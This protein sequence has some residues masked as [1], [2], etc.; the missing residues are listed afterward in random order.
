VVLLK[1]E[2]YIHRKWFICERGFAN[3]RRSPGDL[4]YGLAYELSESDERS[5]DGYEGVPNNYVK[6]YHTINFPDSAER[7]EIKA[8]IY[9]NE[10]LLEEGTPKTEY[11]YRMN[12]AI[13]DCTGA[14]VP[15]EYIKKYLRP[16]IPEISGEK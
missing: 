11:I 16:F 2:K 8:L 7:L 14:G 6:E 5:L 4:V 13:K 9:I 3:I 1:D 15:E 10:E 12:M